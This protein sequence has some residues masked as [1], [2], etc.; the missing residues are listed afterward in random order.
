MSEVSCGECHEAANE[1][2]LLGCGHTFCLKCV[3][4]KPEKC[5]RCDEPVSLFNLISKPPSTS[6]TAISQTQLGEKLK[7]KLEYFE[8]EEQDCLSLFEE[9]PAKQKNAI[10]RIQNELEKLIKNAKKKTEASI[11]EINMES[12]ES[13][14]D[15]EIKLE[16]CR[17][18]KD[19]LGNVKAMLDC[20]WD[21][22]QDMLSFKAV[23]RFINGY[24]PPDLI[25]VGNKKGLD[26]LE[27]G[28]TDE[29]IAI[30][31]KQED[32]SC[33]MVNSDPPHLQHNL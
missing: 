15:N 31:R 5:R 28:I 26:I 24:I 10:E 12:Q 17:K 33:I 20:G 27:D 7:R 18:T 6:S 32:V 22:N 21:I 13:L 16:Q 30:D 29:R 9:I 25:D 2:Q 23:K 14:M 1:M 8:R 19:Q 4:T 11:E 3:S